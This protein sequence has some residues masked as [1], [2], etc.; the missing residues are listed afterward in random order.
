LAGKIKKMIDE[1]I[2]ER[3]RGNP[4]ITEMTIAKLILKRV[5]PNKFDVNSLDD[6]V[7][8]K[9]LLLLLRNIIM[10]VYTT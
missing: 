1:I 4:A 7:I 6:E 8:I 5:N 3:S 2:Q 10:R 9:K